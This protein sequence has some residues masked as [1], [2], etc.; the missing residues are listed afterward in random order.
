MSVA[1]Y[2]RTIRESESPRQ[3]ERRVLS[4]ITGRMEID[5]ERYDMT[6]DRLERGAILAQGLRDALRDNATAWS[7]MRHDLAETGNA[8]PPQLKAGLISISLWVERQTTAVMGGAGGVSAL[9]EV[10][11]NIIDGLSGIA[12]RSA[13]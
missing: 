2:R 11:R 10:N 1:A 6:Q 12:P 13:A 3:I 5:A 9:A 4:Q 7:I 8:L